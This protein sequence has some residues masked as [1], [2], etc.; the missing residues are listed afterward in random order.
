MDGSRR[1]TKVRI[2]IVELDWLKF[3]GINVTAACEFAILDA[4]H[5][6]DNPKQYLVDAII[7]RC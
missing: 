1:Y 6:Y 7:S 5:Y 4:L 3:N 2:P